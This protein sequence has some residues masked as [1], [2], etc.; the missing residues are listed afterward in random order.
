MTFALAATWGLRSNFMLM[1]RWRPFRAHAG[2][3][4][5]V[6]T[7]RMPSMISALAATFPAA[8]SLALRR[9]NAGDRAPLK[10]Q[11]KEAMKFGPTAGFGGSEGQPG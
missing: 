11:P 8:Y 2:A 4:S 9:R 3:G 1:S 5:A 10:A 7:A 6:P